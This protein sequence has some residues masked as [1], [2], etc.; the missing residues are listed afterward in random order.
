MLT[1]KHDGSEDTIISCFRSSSPCSEGAPLLKDQVNIL[2]NDDIGSSNQFEVTVS[3]VDEADNKAKVIDE[4][5]DED[6]FIDKEWRCNINVLL[7]KY[8]FT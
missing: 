3:D 8:D 1:L 6:D 4:S 2:N 5:G 7:T